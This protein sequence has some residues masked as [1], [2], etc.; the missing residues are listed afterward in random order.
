MRLLEPTHEAWPPGGIGPKDRQIAVLMSGGVDSSVAAMLLK[1]AG[2][3]AV[4]VTLVI[5]AAENCARSNPCCGAMVGK[6]CREIGIPHYYMD[7]KEEFREL[8]IDRFR[9]SYEAGMTPNPCA[10]CNNEIKFGLA[11]DLIRREMGIERLATGHYARIVREG[12]RTLLSRATDRDKDQSYFLYGIRRERLE[13]LHLPLGDICKG[14]VRELARRRGLSAAERPES[15][16]LCFVGGEDYREAVG[17][18]GETHRKGPIVDSSGRV[19]GEHDGASR[20]TI[21]QRKGLRIPAREPLFVVAIRPETNTVVV[22]TRKEAERIR[23]TADRVNVLMPDRWRSGERLF[24]RIRSSGE[25]APCT[26]SAASGEAVSV[27]FDEPCFAPASG[28]RLVLYDA[29]GIVV[30]GGVIVS[31]SEV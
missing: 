17:A 2:W 20:F 5:P 3:E 30:G 1:D 8:V 7:V 29:D 24:G 28:Q 27:E 21:G 23:V 26:V 4:G 13:R 18:S 25:P 11:W 19:L 15:Q 9:R 14:E 10:D 16:D 12:G 31:E 22:G 6:V